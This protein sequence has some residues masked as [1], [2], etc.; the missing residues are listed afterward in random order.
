MIG[1][2]LKYTAAVVA[3]AVLFATCMHHADENAYEAIKAHLD[4]HETLVRRQG[5]LDAEGLRETMRNYIAANRP[6]WDTTYTM[7]ETGRRVEQLY[8]RWA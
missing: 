6:L 1:T 8:S 4:D 3:G 5:N 2:V 7:A